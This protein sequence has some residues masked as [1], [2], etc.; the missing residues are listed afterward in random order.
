M[1]IV[2]TGGGRKKIA[3]LSSDD[4]RRLFKRS[5]DEYLKENERDIPEMPSKGEQT[6][7]LDDLVS[8]WQDAVEMLVDTA[9]DQ[10][11][12]ILIDTPD[13]EEADSEESD[14]ADDAD[15]DEE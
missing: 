14:D 1:A 9:V 10:Y 6:E 15:E 12:S 4:L 5:M 11:C 3:E 7:M 2:R 8:L 13:E